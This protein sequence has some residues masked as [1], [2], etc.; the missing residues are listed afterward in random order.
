M[1]EGS[2]ATQSLAL[3]QITF[4]GVAEK[5]RRLRVVLMRDAD[6]ILPTSGA[7]QGT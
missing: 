3:A 4:E 6:Q 2:T 5:D 1:T 7:D